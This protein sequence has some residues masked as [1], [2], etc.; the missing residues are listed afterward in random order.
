MIRY[1]L[2]QDGVV[3]LAVYDARGRRVR[4]LVETYQEG[5]Q[6]YAVGFEADRLA[7]GSYYYRLRVEGFASIVFDETRSLMIVR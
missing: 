7:S 4:S 2:E 3:S 6:W 1:Y 5:D